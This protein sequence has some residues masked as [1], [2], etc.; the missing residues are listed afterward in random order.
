MAPL[1]F[2]DLLPTLPTFS[3][4][5]ETAFKTLGIY[6]ACLPLTI[7]H[8]CIRLIQAEDVTS[9]KESLTEYGQIISSTEV[10]GRE[11]SIIELKEPLSIG[12]WQTRGLELPYPKQNHRYE[13]GFEHV[14]FVLPHTE[15]TLDGVRHTFFATFP[16]LKREALEANYQ[17]SEDEPHAAS[18]QLPNP[19]IGLTV[20]GIGIKFHS[21]PIQTVVGFTS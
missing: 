14:E 5:L 15:H 8:I 10:N 12:A 9:V 4:R 2:A 11:I 7:D 21:L 20:E 19:T 16:T 1:S 13:D 18:D 3:E 17:Y 6:K